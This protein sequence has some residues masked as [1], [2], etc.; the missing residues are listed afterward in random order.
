MNTITYSSEFRKVLQLAKEKGLFLGTG[1][2]NGKIVFIGKEA[3]IDEKLYPEQHNRELTNN[4]SDWENNYTN[5]IQFSKVD[6]WFDRSKYN[7]LYPYKGQR[8][9]IES[10]NKKGEIVRGNGGTSKTW[11]NYQKIINSVYF[12][13][14][15]NNLI[16]YH[17]YAFCSELN[18]VTGPYSK[19]IPKKIRKESIDK[20]KELFQHTFF[21]EFTITIVAVGHYVR[22]FN[23][24]L[25]DVFQMKFNE[26]LSKKLSEALNNEYINVHFD[27]LEKP[28]RLLIHT[29][30]LSMVSNDLIK[31][32]GEV[33]SLFLDGK[34]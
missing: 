9:T 24:D 34:I 30:Q 32:V 14:S 17:E 28:T 13:N 11:Y 12:K 1:N 7:P 15:S 6:N 22:D 33:C 10:R 2:P 20:R 19:T 26:E 18:Q 5:K 4:L 8:N 23:I 16:N 29:N 25:Q 21:K 27:D 3:A 31:K